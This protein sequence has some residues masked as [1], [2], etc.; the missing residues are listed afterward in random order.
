M[1]GPRSDLSVASTDYLAMLDGA[2]FAA[3]GALLSVTLTSEWV[4]ARWPS[5]RRLLHDMPAAVLR[6]KTASLIWAVVVGA[7]LGNYFCSGVAKLQAGGQEPWTWLLANPTQMAIAIGLES[8]NNPLAAFPTLLQFGW[9]TL[10]NLA[11]PLNFFVLG[12]Q[13]LAS[14]SIFRVRSLLLFTLLFDIFH[15]GVYLTLGALFHFWIAVNLIICA[16]AWRLKESE[17]T[18]TM[19]V[20]CILATLFGHTIFFTNFLGWLD[21]AQ[22]VSPRFY[23]VTK[24]GQRERVSP[25]YFGT[26]SYTV[27]HGALYIPEGHFP[28]RYGGNTHNL[29]D[30]REATAVSR[31]EALPSRSVARHAIQSNN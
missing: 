24:D 25:A 23:A 17:L 31:D 10:S 7:H 4:L 3:I 21:A 26:Y 1:I 6:Q 12:S 20:T 18:P 16:S 5:L 11:L 22:L 14:T 30:W 29:K 15:I 13:L 8:G 19:K 2:T 9:D 28:H 27:G